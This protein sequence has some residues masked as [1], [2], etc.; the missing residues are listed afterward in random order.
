[1]A[2][3]PSTSPDDILGVLERVL[4]GDASVAERE[5]AEQW[6][7]AHPDVRLAI[8]AYRASVW[9]RS[10]SGGALDARQ[11][12]ERL[13]LK[14]HD[15]LQTDS[16]ITRGTESETPAVLSERR[17]RR[18]RRG[19]DGS[20]RNRIGRFVIP[21]GLFGGAILVGLFVLRAGSLQHSGE[22]AV[23][24]S[25]HYATA[26]GERGAVTLADG[27]RVT[28]APQSALDVVT[29]AN[30]HRVATLTGEAYFDVT[31]H[32]DA[33]F[34]V[35]TRLGTA[36]VLGT[37]F[38]IRHYPTDAALRIAVASGKVEVTGAR[39]PVIVTAG[40]VAVVTDSTMMADVRPERGEQAAWKDG[41]LVFRDIPV[42]EMLQTVGRW[43]GYEFRLRDSTL[44]TQHV[45]ASIKLNTNT[46]LLMNAIKSLLD[47]T[48]T[49]D[50]E[51]VTLQARRTAKTFALPRTHQRDAFSPPL[52]IGK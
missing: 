30:G 35:R 7:A 22:S 36:R 23:V 25:R 19:P 21:A 17:G 40:S 49:F 42:P 14:M 46:T 41:Q 33:P 45:T 32:A 24:S 11:S 1:M 31:P 29:F 52:E 3:F 10:V 18:W 2:D 15:E 34:A 12:L 8:E 5:R 27:S 47:V 28:L 16:R 43:Y 9:E 6:L 13:H 26:T 50:G 39:V 51:V 37:A 20:L 4:A 44:A 38:D 48:M